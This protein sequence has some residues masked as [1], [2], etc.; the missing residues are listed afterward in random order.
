MSFASQ[1]RA[2][3]ATNAQDPRVLC[4]RILG[5]F[6]Y[7]RNSF[8]RQKINEMTETLPNE[9]KSSNWQNIYQMAESLPN[10]RTSTTWQKVYQ[11]AERY[12]TGRKVAKWQKGVHTM[13]SIQQGFTQWLVSFVY[14]IAR[15]FMFPEI[16][17]SVL[18]RLR[19]RLLPNS[20]ALFVAL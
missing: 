19:S 1:V 17:Q 7:G 9:R 2:T 8:K 20:H 3:T 13:I 5:S 16:H 10:D 14:I 18:A 15:A 12:S 6:H 4:T 11:M